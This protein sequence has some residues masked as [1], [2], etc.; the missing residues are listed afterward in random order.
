VDNNTLEL[1]VAKLDL[2]KLDLPSE[3][4]VYKILP[5]T[6]SPNDLIKIYKNLENKYGYVDNDEGKLY[7]FKK[8]DFDFIPK[9]IKS[10]VDINFEA[11]IEFN[12]NLK[13]SDKIL[14]TYIRTTI[15]RDI[16][17][18]LKDIN[19]KLLASNTI[20]GKWI[21]SLELDNLAIEKV[22]ENFYIAFNI[23]LRIL[24]N[25]NLWDFVGRNVK[26]LKALCWDPDN[27]KDNKIWFRYVPDIKEIESR[28]YIL[29]DVKDENELTN[30]ELNFEYLKYYPIEERSLTNEELKNLA[31]FRDFDENQPIIKGIRNIND[32]LYS[33][34]PQY[35]I[36][37]YSP[38]LA[39]KEEIKIVEKIKNDIV[40]NKKAEVIKK[41]IK[42]LDYLQE[43]KLEDIQVHNLEEVPL[44]ARFVKVKLQLKKHNKDD[45]IKDIKVEVLGK[46]YEKTITSIADLFKW[47]HRLEDLTSGKKKELIV[48]VPVPEY[49]PESIKNLTEIPAFILIESGGKNKISEKVIKSFL[50]QIGL[51][52]KIIR[53]ASDDLIPILKF[54]KNP[55]TKSII[56][57]FE[58]NEISVG[59]IARSVREALNKTGKELGFAFIFGNKHE[60][61]IE[62]EEEEEVE[63][64]DY[65]IPIKK[66]LFNENIISQ[67]FLIFTYTHDDGTLDEKKLKFS[68]SN[69]VYNL[70]GKLGIK[71]FVLEEQMPYDFILGIDT[72]FSE[73]YTGRVAGCTTIHDSE[74]RL[75]NIIPIEKLNP[76]HRESARV[77]VLMEEIE[78]KMGV[79]FSQKRILI[80]RDGKIQRK[81]LEQLKK[82]AEQRDCKLTII[83]IRKNNVYQWIAKSDNNHKSIRIGKV[84]LLKAHKPKRGFPRLVK[85]AEKAEVDKDGISFKEINKKDVL[86]IYK[87]TSLNYSVI[88]R[89]SNLKIPAPIYYADKLVKALKRGW[90]L[91]SKL[92]QE[93]VL[94]FL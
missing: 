91:E 7:S 30:S 39:T 33:F 56:F 40:Y 13:G 82:F 8:I 79:S 77:K 23:K 59:N 29:V 25:K 1:N 69:I 49:I 53:E 27:P 68:L 18:L 57:S 35:C 44:K 81:E 4:Y 43:W 45:N 87:L 19:K 83:G 10:K 50:N 47:I 66:F 80:L 31:K 75:R 89:P 72:G 85:I 71:F 34:L 28:S 42:E 24:G 22:N 12:R 16:H 84:W 20:V 2:E 73:A 86:L 17:N 58:N 15:K 36:P 9:R 60:L 3:I 94:Y 6:T 48:D 78:V 52:Y 11:S 32:K 51:I 21:L 74:G 63:D 46:A 62:V 70:F 54:K 90:K 67:N 37:S 76:A 65:Y 5:K 93:G 26:K 92:L 14:K 41:V 61:T 55:N 64:Y 38:H 88:G